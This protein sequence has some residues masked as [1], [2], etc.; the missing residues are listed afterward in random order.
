MLWIVNYEYQTRDLNVRNMEWRSVSSLNSDSVV[1]DMP[2]S[3]SFYDA[4]NHIKRERP[5][6]AFRQ[7]KTLRI[8]SIQ[9]HP[10]YAC[11]N[12]N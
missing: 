10:A 6:V 12:E 11:L 3:L 1:M 4:E 5:A 9:K 8:L 7:Y 2:N